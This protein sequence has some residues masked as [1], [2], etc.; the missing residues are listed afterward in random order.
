MGQVAETDYIKKL[1]KKIYRK[2]YKNNLV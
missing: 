1:K 2:L